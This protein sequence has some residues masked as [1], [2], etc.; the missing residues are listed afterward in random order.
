ML[1]FSSLTYF[2]LSLSLLKQLHSV[3][4]FGMGDSPALFDKNLKTFLSGLDKVTRL[5]SL[6]YIRPTP[7]FNRV[8]TSPSPSFN[9]L[10]T[11]PPTFPSL[12]HFCVQKGNSSSTSTF[13]HGKG[14]PSRHG[15]LVPVH[16][17]KLCCTWCSYCTRG[18]KIVKC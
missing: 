8:H 15:V 12:S 5:T 16:R 7:S 11:L 4:P 6:F 1:Q 9:R 2:F 14:C 13:L 3:N 10:H 17:I 18:K